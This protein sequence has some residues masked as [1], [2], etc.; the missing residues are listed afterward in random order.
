MN[1]GTDNLSSVPQAADRDLRF[2]RMLQR[3][4]GENGVFLL[5]VYTFLALLA[6]VIVSVLSVGYAS[7]GIRNV[8]DRTSSAVHQVP[9]LLQPETLR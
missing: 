1:R 3:Q 9:A 2:K 7:L 8:A 4:L 6:V 5:S